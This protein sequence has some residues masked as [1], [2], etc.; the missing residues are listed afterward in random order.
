MII[1]GNVITPDEGKKL[2]NGLGAYSYKV[3]L[4][5]NDSPD[6]WSEVD[7]DAPETEPEAEPTEADK[8]EAFDILTGVSE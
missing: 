6:N 5:T 7:A 1:T 8:A 3:Y 2:T 4:G